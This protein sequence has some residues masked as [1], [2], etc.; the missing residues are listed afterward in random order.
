MLSQIF[1]ANVK[2]H[3]TILSIDFVDTLPLDA[4]GNSGIVL[5]IWGN[6]SKFTYSTIIVKTNGFSE[7]YR[8]IGIRETPQFPIYSP[9]L[10]KSVIYS[11]YCLRNINFN[12]LTVGIKKLYSD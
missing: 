3:S 7:G 10:N 8:K 2:S 1:C 11:L 6:G 5:H 12:L 4:I 9:V